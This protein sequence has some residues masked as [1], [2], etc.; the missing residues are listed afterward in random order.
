MFRPPPRRLAAAKIAAILTAGSLTLT[1]GRTPVLA[2]SAEG[3]ALAYISIPLDGSRKDW[4]TAL[5]LDLGN[6]HGA[7]PAGGLG[8]RSDDPPPVVEVRFGVGEE[9]GELRL[10]ALRRPGSLTG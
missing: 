2:Q 9:P 8:P 5:R 7:E 1:S 3:H 6:R 4:L 10:G